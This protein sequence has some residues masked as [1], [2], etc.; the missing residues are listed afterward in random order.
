MLYALALVAFFS[1]APQPVERE[2]VPTT[3]VPPRIVQAKFAAD[4]K[5]HT[6]VAEQVPQTVEETRQQVVNGRT[7]PY[8]VSKTVYVPV[9]RETIHDPKSV[10]FYDLE[11]K[12]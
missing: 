7:I 1:P 4:G 12:K 9:M 2:P 8:R 11:G 5:L 10:T 6:L 3:N